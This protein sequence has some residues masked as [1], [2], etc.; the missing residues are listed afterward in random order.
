LNCQSNKQG[1]NV[2]ADATTTEPSALENAEKKKGVSESIQAWHTLSSETLSERLKADMSNKL[3]L[4]EAK[5]GL[6]KSGPNT[7]I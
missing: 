5:S 3:T 4:A 6:A 2:I 1:F 7:M